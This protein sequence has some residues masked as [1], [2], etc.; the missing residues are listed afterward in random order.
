[1]ATPRDSYTFLN[2]D[3][4]PP[5]PRDTLTTILRHWDNTTDASN[6]YLQY[7]APDAVLSFGGEHRG[8]DG[9]R[10]CH[11][12]MIHPKTGPIVKCQHFFEK[13]YVPGSS[14]GGEE[15]GKWEIIGVADVRYTLVNGKEV[16]TRAAS[17]ATLAK[18]EEGRWIAQRYEVFMDGSEL[19]K[20]IGL[21]GR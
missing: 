5:I 14:D 2:H 13:A 12:S 19:M 20:E 3:T 16:T 8:R 15:S 9:I 21:L 6:T 17:F 1:M 11:D 4:L 7:F 10:A 18:G